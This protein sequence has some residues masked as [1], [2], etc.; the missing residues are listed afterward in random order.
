MTKY[1]VTL[2]VDATV[3]V[4]VEANSK[5]EAREKALDTA[6]TPSVCH[7]CSSKVMIGDILENEDDDLVEE[8]KEATS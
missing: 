1:R 5:R 2:L 6:D 3:T 7:K 8:L 4:D